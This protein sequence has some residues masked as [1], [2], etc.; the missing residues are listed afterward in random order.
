MV[1]DKIA[2]LGFG[3]S[4]Q[5]FASL[6]SQRLPEAEL[7]VYSSQRLPGESFY[8]TSDLSEVLKFEPTIAIIC[9]VA[10]DRLAMVKA[11]PKEMRGVL[12][13][14]PLAVN[15]EEGIH[16]TKELAQR[17]GITQVGYNLRFSSSLHEFKRKVDSLRFGRV[18]SLRAE[19]GQYLPDWRTG[20]DYRTTASAR[21]ESGGGVLLELSH[22]IDY[23]RWIFGDIEWVSGWCGKQSDLEIDV[24]DTAH[25]TLGFSPEAALPMLVGQLNLD[26]T[27]HDRTRSITAVCAE[28]TLRWDGIALRVE[29][30]PQGGAGWE[31]SYAEEALAPNS[32][33]RQWDSFYLAVTTGVTPEV[34]VEDGLAVLSVIDAARSSHDSQGI[35]VSPPHTG[36]SS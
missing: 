36:H 9:G 27:R 5:R 35:R 4:G 18:L 25:L 24:E 31:V 17:G 3:S 11:L 28:G 29:E 7:L 23:L 33:E 2:V 10:S 6:V 26:F 13:E 12:I 1:K 15:Y 22:E 14:K 8:F 30:W 20:R 16:V 21:G 32:S 34:T 19:T